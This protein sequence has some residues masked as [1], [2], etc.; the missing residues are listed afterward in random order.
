MVVLPK[1]VTCTEQTACHNNTPRPSWEDYAHARSITSVSRGNNG[2]Q[3]ARIGRHVSIELGQSFVVG[4]ARRGTDYGSVAPNIVGNNSG[5]GMSQAQGVLEVR[6]I[7]RLVGVYEDE[8]ECLARQAV[9]RFDC[10]SNHNF[11][12]LFNT[13]TPKA[14][15]SQFGV[16]WRKLQRCN[17]TFGLKRAREQDRAIAEESSNFEDSARAALHY[18]HLQKATEFKGHLDGRET[19]LFCFRA[20]GAEYIILTTIERLHI[21]R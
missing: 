14:G 7:R 18:K 16:L 1:M 20:H 10:W 11:D 13:G 21:I 2:R 19:V 9:Q 4:V 15:I 5:A 6:R 17:P 8:V 12:T 3:K